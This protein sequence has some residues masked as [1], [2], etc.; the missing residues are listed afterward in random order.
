VR[1]G[2]ALHDRFL[3]PTFLWRDLEDVLAFL[4]RAELAL[5]TDVY[6][7]FLELRCPVAGRLEAEDVLVEIRNALE[8][9]PVLGEEPAGG[10]TSRFVDSSVER[11][12]V[13]AEGL[14]P[15]RHVVLVNGHVLPLRST[16]R[17]GEGAAGVRFRAWAPARSLQS[18]LGVHHPLRIDVLDRW[19]GRSLGACA[20]HVFHPEGR[21]YASQ[22]LTRFEAS[23]RRT[24]R[25]TIEAPL[26]APVTPAPAATHD[27]T[28]WTLD[29]RRYAIDHPL[30]PPL[31]PL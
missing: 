28:A 18:H 31:D 5:P 19:S 23:A 6:R 30:P 27:D 3:L 4:A 7:A 15:E 24:Q 21:A 12:E 2:T 1:W 26:R 13:R 20:Y 29:L 14:V 25:F 11:I 16:G 22:P 9:W 8:P 10:G 17:A